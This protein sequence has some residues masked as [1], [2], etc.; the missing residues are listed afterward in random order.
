[1][2]ATEDGQG[3]WF[4]ASDGGVA[5]TGYRVRMGE[6]FPYDAPVEG[7]VIVSATLEP[8]TC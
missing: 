8:N 2:A 7:R 4:V 3:Y 6:S 1:M 5:A